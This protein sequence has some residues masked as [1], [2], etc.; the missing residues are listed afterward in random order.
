MFI[1]LS[2]VFRSHNAIHNLKF[3]TLLRIIIIVRRY[4]VSNIIVIYIFLYYTLQI[5]FISLLS[6]GVSF[7]FFLFFKSPI[8]KYMFCTCVR[9]NTKAIIDNKSLKHY[10]ETALIWHK[11]RNLAQ[12]YKSE[13]AFSLLRVTA[14]YK[15][16]L[17]MRI[18]LEENQQNGTVIREC[19]VRMPLFLNENLH[20]FHS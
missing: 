16:S 6:K 18:K 10:Q 11:H 9:K 2:M 7:S 17:A 4:Q 8:T 20:F 13:C 15:I 5:I 3:F 14:K 1:W 19:F 12:F